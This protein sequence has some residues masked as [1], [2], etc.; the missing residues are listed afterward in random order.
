MFEHPIWK[1]WPAGGVHP[2]GTMPHSAVPVVSTLA[3]AVAVISSRVMP[4]T[5][6]SV[7][8]TDWSPWRRVVTRTMPGPGN[9][10]SAASS[11]I[12]C[13]SL[14]NALLLSAATCARGTATSVWISPVLGSSAEAPASAAASAAFWSWVRVAASF[15]T[16][17][18]SEP[19][20]KRRSRKSAIQTMMAPRSLRAPD[21]RG[22]TFMAS[23]RSVRSVG[24]QHR[25]GGRRRDQL[26]RDDDHELVIH[27]VG[28]GVREEEANQR[29]H[30]QDRHAL[31]GM[32][33]VG[34]LE[35]ADHQVLAA[36]QV[37]RGRDQAVHDR[38]DLI[39]GRG[40]RVAVIQLAHLGIHPQRDAAVFL[41]DRGE[42]HQHAV[43]LPLDGHGRVAV[44]GRGGRHRDRD[45]TAGAE[46]GP[47][48]AARHQG[49]L[50]ED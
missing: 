49:R 26:G 47:L 10:T 48:A 44:A 22:G 42:V 16:S 7:V 29:D 41:D 6:A 38:R 19:K 50:G 25:L 31:D 24:R 14:T 30:A 40:Q 8:T 45:L 5:W 32:D 20:A 9:V 15:A 43:V 18:P 13:G 39:A 35:P 2:S 34:L 12:G 28:D 1:V 21:P 23:V 33:P 11:T 36:L 46:G 17:T 4:S 37:H 27:V 3:V